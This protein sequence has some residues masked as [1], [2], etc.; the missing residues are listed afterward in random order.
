[1]TSTAQ[2]LT[3]ADAFRER[4]AGYRQAAE[5]ARGDG[6]TAEA[7]Q[8]DAVAVDYDAAAER[9]ELAQL[10]AAEPEKPKRMTMGRVVEQLLESRGR[11]GAKSAAVTIGRSARGIVTW[12]ITATAD[13]DELEQLDDALAAAIAAH[14][15]L[16]GAYPMPEGE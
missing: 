13:P 10:P 14:D 11:G 7:E 16:A 6:Y 1:M 4:A 3:F 8:Y 15:Q 9:L 2:P 12:E 5:A